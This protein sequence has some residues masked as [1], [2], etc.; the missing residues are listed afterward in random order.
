MDNIVENNKLI[1]EFMGYVLKPC[2]NGKAWEYTVSHSSKDDIFKL[3]GRLY[4]GIESDMKFHKSW[5]W[6]MP[7]FIRI[8]ETKY[9]LTGGDEY[10]TYDIKMDG[11]FVWID[12]PLGDRI[13]FS[14]NSSEMIY[15]PLIEKL[16]TSIIRFIKWYNKRGKR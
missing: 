5:A 14:G 16:Y 8:N 1:A 13:A 12:P 3:H 2:N 7:V 10:G 9:H 11:E 6:L 15:K 4:H